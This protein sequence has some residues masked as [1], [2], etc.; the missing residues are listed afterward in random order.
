MPPARPMALRPGRLRGADG[1][2]L[3]PHQ[4][5]VDVVALL[6]WSSGPVAV[7]LLAVAEADEAAGS[8]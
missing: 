1:D 6:L 5:A 3:D 2:N 4:T 7:S 8:G